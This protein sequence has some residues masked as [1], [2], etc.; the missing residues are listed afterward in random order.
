MSGLG[1]SKALPITAPVAAPMITH[2][3]SFYLVRLTFIYVTFYLYYSGFL[4]LYYKPLLAVMPTE[5]M[6]KVSMPAMK[7]AGELR[8]ANP[9][10]TQAEAVKKA[11][12]TPEILA[13][14]AAYEKA[15]PKK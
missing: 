10:L 9:K 8:K 4:C 6:K 12:K 3:I 7:K 14:K 1:L 11:W 2:S 5:Y 13:A 15:H